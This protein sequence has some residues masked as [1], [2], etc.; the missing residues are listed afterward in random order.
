MLENASCDK[1]RL[2]FVVLLI[3]WLMKKSQFWLILILAWMIVAGLASAK[4]YAYSQVH[5]D[6]G[7]QLSRPLLPE[8]TST[9]S[10]L[11]TLMATNIPADR[12][13]PPVG[14][15]VGMVLGASVLVLIIIGGVLGFRKRA[16]RYVKH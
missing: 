5:T 16:S 8:I 10:A 15:N 7:V 11:P 14:K 4:A 1:L 2:R 3:D 6:K 12:Q 13:L 9:P